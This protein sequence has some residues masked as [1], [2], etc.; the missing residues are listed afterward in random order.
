M[1]V[2]ELIKN[3]PIEK[4]DANI[5]PVIEGLSVGQPV[6]YA[7]MLAVLALLANK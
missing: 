6:L 3:A 7:A 2:A 4:E 1:V 5:Y